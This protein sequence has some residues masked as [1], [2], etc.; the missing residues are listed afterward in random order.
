MCQLMASLYYSLSVKLIFI[1]NINLLNFD[2][3]DARNIFHQ[4]Q[5]VATRPELPPLP[6]NMGR[7][8]LLVD[9]PVIKKSS[10]A[11]DKDDATNLGM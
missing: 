1:A 2:I 10:L 9:Q 8:N 5:L 3:S 11:S 4:L 7:G 6:D